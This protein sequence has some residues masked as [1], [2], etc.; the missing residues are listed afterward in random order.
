MA[1]TERDIENLRKL[2]GYL[3]TPR[4]IGEIATYLGVSRMRDLDYIE[5]MVVN[6]KRYNISCENLGGVEKCWVVQ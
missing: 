1:I 4:T 3:R 6:P 2:E 5:V